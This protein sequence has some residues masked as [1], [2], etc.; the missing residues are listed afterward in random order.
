LQSF[1]LNPCFSFD[2]QVEF[3]KRRSA[4]DPKCGSHAL[5]RFKKSAGGFDTKSWSLN[6]IKI[7]NKAKK[8]VLSRPLFET[9]NEVSDLKIV[10]IFLKLI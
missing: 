8:L 4:C 7:S 1:H 5:R 3:W 9:L 10:T 2:L 6:S